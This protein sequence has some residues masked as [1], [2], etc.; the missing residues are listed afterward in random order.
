MAKK[1]D[2]VPELD[3]EQ[4]RRLAAREDHEFA[5]GNRESR[6]EPLNVNEEPDTTVD[7]EAV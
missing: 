6:P 7:Y 2:V 3:A 5:L 1:K 4:K